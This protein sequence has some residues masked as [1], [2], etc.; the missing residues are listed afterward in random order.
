MFSGFDSNKLKVQ[1]KLSINRLKMLQQKKHVLNLSQRR[2]IA[3][4]LEKGK[5]E[6]AR[7]RVEHIIREDYNMEAME[8]M[9][10]YCEMLLAR[11]G[12]IE[13][14]KQL[15]PSIAEATCSL[16]YA[17]PRAEAKELMTVRDLLLAKYGK[18]LGLEKK[19][20]SDSTVDVNERLVEKLRVKVP[21]HKLVTRYL[22]E[23]ARNYNVPWG[24]GIEENLIDSSLLGS[25]DSNSF[26]ASM[27]TKDTPVPP[28]T[29]QNSSPYNPYPP[30][31][32]SLPEPPPHGFVNPGPVSAPISPGQPPYPTNGHGASNASASPFDESSFPSVPPTDPK[33]P[34][35]G[36]DDNNDDGGEDA[37]D[38]DELTR[39]FEALKR[40][41]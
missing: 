26:S 29:P 39:R 19:T 15:D 23:I 28:Y 35:G 25:L 4:L 20:A 3:T 11:F 31:N 33:G 13:Q 30:D 21:D 6:S 10:I 34:Y 1:L 41:T 32:Y 8:M 24:E 22:Q 16:I 7:I 27:I 2:E 18:E 9:E 37:P 38:F 17:A 36:D 5:E 40:R 12:L 14:M